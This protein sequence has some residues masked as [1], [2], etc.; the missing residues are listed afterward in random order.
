LSDLPVVRISRRGADRIIS[1]HPWIFSSD[2]IDRGKATPG[3][4]VSVADQRGK[5]VGTAHFSS[6]SQICLRLL[7]RHVEPAGPDF[8]RRRIEAAESHRKR[9]VNDSDSYRLVHGEGDLLPALIIDRYSDTFVVQTLDQG[10]DRAK[11][12]IVSVLEKLF[13][14]RAIIERNDAAVRKREDLPLVSGVLSGDDPGSVAIHMNGLALHADLLRGQKTGVYLDQRENYVAARKYA[15]GRALDC[16][17]STGGFALHIA[18][19]CEHVTA[20]DSSATAL[21]TAARNASANGI[22]NV[23]WREANVFDFLT[24]LRLS[25]ARRFSTIVLDPPAFA[26]SR[27]AVEDAAR[28]YKELNLRAMQLLEP[29]GVLITCSCSHHF[30]EPMFAET[31]AAAAVDTGRTVR[32]LERRTQAQDHPILLTVPET[33]Y[34]KCLILQVL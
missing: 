4:V 24:G 23:E 8:F 34:L 17:T 18:H 10:M 20:I 21:E 14:P 9:V 22:G 2:V 26:K 6:A 12:D 13:S 3:A 5:P 11:P 27:S 7:S 15:R 33:M 29:G 16:F 19:N 30:S 25:A 32:V 28:G 1:G 31:V